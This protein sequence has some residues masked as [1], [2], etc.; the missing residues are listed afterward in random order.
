M[1]VSS[2]YRFENQNSIYYLKPNSQSIYLLD[3]TLKGFCQENLRWKRG[4][5]GVI[6]AHATSTQTSDASI[7]IVGGF[8]KTSIS[9]GGT[10]L[11]DCL[12]V[13]ANLGVYERE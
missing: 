1:T 4:Q 11:K 2:R 8:K 7:Y 12:M 6:P 9:D 3:F 10:A 5:E 13:D